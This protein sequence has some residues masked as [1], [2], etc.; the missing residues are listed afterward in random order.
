MSTTPR[1]PTPTMSPVPEKW[2]W[3]M[4]EEAL[5][6]N[7]T[8]RPIRPNQVAMYSRL[9]KEKN[10]GAEDAK[11]G[12]RAD[13]GPIV[14]DWDGNLVNGQHRLLAQ[15]ASKTTQYYYVLRDVPP[16]TQRNI[17]NLIMR[18]AADELHAGGHKNY[19]I[20]SSVARWAWLLERGH[21]ADSKV[22]VS[23]PE[24]VAMVDK[25]PDLHHSTDAATRSR[26]G[27]VVKGCIGPTPIGAAHWWIAQHNDHA[28]ADM[29]VDRM[30][31]V[32]GERE[33]SAINALLNR[34][35][36]AKARNERLHTRTEITMIIRAWNLDVERGYV[37]R[38]ATKNKSGEYELPE[39]AKRIVSQE[40]S[41]G[42]MSDAEFAVENESEF[43]P[44]PEKAKPDELL[45]ARDKAKAEPE[46]EG[47]AW[48]KKAA[49]SKAKPAAKKA[50]TD[51]DTSAKPAAAKDEPKA[52]KKA[53]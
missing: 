33:G 14:F 4:A 38:L 40:D 17:D 53:S 32:N 2:T 7:A 12:F 31:N 24:I 5:Q 52:P 48:V 26:N 13:S 51:T 43:E 28:E 29:F 10:W 35:G 16:S 30:V 34:L 6:K 36:S 11:Q 18:K 42:P 41:F 8:N 25:H 9:M 45:K 23:A 22:K 15:V 37:S 39:V 3:Q 19:I 27:W 49:E 46:D 44:E 21:T 47:D 20:L 50:A 1:K